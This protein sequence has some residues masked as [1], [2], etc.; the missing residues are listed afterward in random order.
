MNYYRIKDDIY[1]EDYSTLGGIKRN[2]SDVDADVFTIGAVYDYESAQTFLVEGEVKGKFDFSLASFDVPIVSGRFAR[3]LTGLAENDIQL[4]P[5]RTSCI[6]DFYILN[7]LTRIN[8]LDE[9]RSLFTKWEASDGRPDR[10]GQYRMVAELKIVSEAAEGR[11]IFRIAGW[12]VP[13]IVSEQLMK[14]A[15][16]QDM[17]GCIYE[18]IC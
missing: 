11:C 2:G 13:I 7:I 9:A 6:G 15:Q 17:K 4:I 12:D 10:T 3:L 8:C 16:A 18:L 5:V 1:A 14:L